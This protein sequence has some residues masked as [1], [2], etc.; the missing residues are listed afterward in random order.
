M[1]VLILALGFYFDEI[2]FDNRR[3]VFWVTPSIIIFFFLWKT[4]YF[5]H[6]KK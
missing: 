1:A 3:L 4:N 2:Y 5:T 6:N